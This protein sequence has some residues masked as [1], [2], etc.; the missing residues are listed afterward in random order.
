[1]PV[2]Y[3]ALHEPESMTTPAMVVPCPPI[4]LVALCTTMSA[5]CSIGRIRY[6]DTVSHQR[7]AIGEKGDRITSHAERIVDDQRD[8]VF[9]CDLQDDSIRDVMP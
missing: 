1:V 9:V 7:C 5:P 6:P 2:S 3:V 4:H 8:L